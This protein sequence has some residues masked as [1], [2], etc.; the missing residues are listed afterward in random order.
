MDYIYN[1]F[2][3][4]WCADAAG[5]RL[6]F[7]KK[8]F[9]KKQA[10][11]AMHFTGGKTNGVNDGQFTDD[12]EME[13]ALL[14]ALVKGRDNSNFPIKCI[15]KE[16]IKW[17][18]SDPFDIGSSTMLA[19]S[20]AKTVDDIVNNVNEFNEDSES[21]GS[22]MRCIP[23]AICCLFTPYDT[24]LQIAELDASFTHFS[25]I[26]KLITGIYCCIISEIISCRVNEKNPD[27]VQ[28]L[29]NVNN[30]CKNN[31]T[32]YNW[33]TYG[34]QMSSLN[35]Y[36]AIKNEGH[37]KHAFIMIIYFL[38][39]I[40]KYTYETAIIEVLKCGGDTDTNAKIIGNL[41]G[42]YYINCIPE[43]MSKPVLQFEC[44]K[45]SD[46]FKRPF[47]Y[48]IHYAS[49]LVKKRK[50]TIKENNSLKENN[51]LKENTL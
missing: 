50:W 46:E 22:L 31:E 8:R 42:A 27:I 25:S 43:Y 45:A 15:A 30:M 35:D 6:E 32:V 38:Q 7:R 16:Y 49:K 26:V 40:K 33:Y 5:A 21:N 1:T 48:G 17:Y 12:S 14:T 20:Q 3:A 4:G 29:N 9:T 19:L 11:D 2:L 10:I 37:V 44:T 39:N 51:N 18:N 24:I 34:I 28:L 41:F 13:I 47:Y 23:I 36:N